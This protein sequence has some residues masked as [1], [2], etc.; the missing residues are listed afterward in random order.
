MFLTVKE[1]SNE[2][3][4][5]DAIEFGNTKRGEMVKVVM[6]TNVLTVAFS[7]TM[8]IILLTKIYF[9]YQSTQDI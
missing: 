1:S 6:V 5:S 9:E 3:I 8:I 2:S 4:V 7:G